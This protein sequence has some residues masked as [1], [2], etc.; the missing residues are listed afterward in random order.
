MDPLLI[1]MVGLS[2]WES[3][4]VQTTVDLASGMEIAPWRFVDDPKG[5]D[6]LLVDADHRSPLSERD[7]DESRRPIVVSFAADSDAKLPVASRGL[8]RPVGYMDLISILKDIEQELHATAIRQSRQP[9]V[10]SMKVAPKP[11]AVSAPETRSPL[12]AAL[13]A[14][15]GQPGESLL[16][17]VRPA[18]RFVEETRILG[19][20]NTILRH[21]SSAAVTHP[22]FPTVLI[23]PNNNVF[24]SF[25]DLTSIPRMFR[26][27]ATSFSVSELSVDAEAKALASDRC[28]P[29]GHLLYCAALFGS[30]GRLVLKSGPHDTLCLIGLPDFGVMPHLQEHRK[31]A[32]YM[33]ANSTH[34]A[35]IA[36]STGVSIS[37]VIDFCNACEAVGLLRRIS[38]DGSEYTHGV[39]ERSVLQL[40]GRVRDLF[41]DT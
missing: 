18:R 20:L 9:T 35:D 8:I 14:K 13:L 22:K 31:I 3:V 26:D 29:L 1:S 32:S 6:V 36:S 16:E 25:G 41:K 21:G 38:A 30:E 5:A 28:R 10:L 15:T 40:F 19:L 4:F 39:D 24:V 34:L 23:I 17:K 11:K 27:S 33:M 2:R 37:I 12:T 7:S